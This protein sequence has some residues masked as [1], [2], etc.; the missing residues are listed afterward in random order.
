MTFA[1]KRFAFTLMAAVLLA[2]L[3]ARADEGMWMI[4]AITKALEA[5]KQARGLR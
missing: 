4:N 3:P 1:M 5:D 2:A